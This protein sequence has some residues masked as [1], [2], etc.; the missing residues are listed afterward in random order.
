MKDGKTEV[1]GLR[2]VYIVC[3]NV[4]SCIKKSRVKILKMLTATV[5]HVS[6]HYM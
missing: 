4:I 6:G 3:L 2:T 5:R 1:A